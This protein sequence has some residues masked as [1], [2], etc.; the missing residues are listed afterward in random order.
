MAGSTSPAI[1]ASSQLPPIS[2]TGFNDDLGQIVRIYQQASENE[3]SI[4]KEMME[5]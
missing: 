1:A 2:L 3:R 4:M 5:R